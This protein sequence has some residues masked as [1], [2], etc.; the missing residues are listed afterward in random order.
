[1]KNKPTFAA[2]VKQ[3]T[4]YLSGAG[5]SASAVGDGFS[6]KG[7][8]WNETDLPYLPAEFWPQ[9]LLSATP[10]LL[11]V[12]GLAETA[13]RLNLHHVPFAPTEARTVCAL[14]NSS[15]P[16][17]HDFANRLSAETDSKPNSSAAEE[18]EPHP[19]PS[20]TPVVG[21][22][23]TAPRTVWTVKPR[24]GDVPKPL[25]SSAKSATDAQRV[26][27]ASR[28]LSAHVEGLQSDMPHATNAISPNGYASLQQ[29]HANLCTVLLYDLQIQEI[30][31][32]VWLD[33]AKA[34]DD[35]DAAHGRPSTTLVAEL[36]HY[37][38]RTVAKIVRKLKHGPGSPLNHGG[39]FDSVFGLVRK[40]EAAALVVAKHFTPSGTAAPTALNRALDLL[41]FAHG[42]SLNLPYAVNAL[43]S[44]ISAAE[45]SGVAYDAPLTL[46]RIEA[47]IAISS[48]E[49]IPLVTEAGAAT[50]WAVWANDRANAGALRGAAPVS[51]EDVHDLMDELSVLAI[52]QSK[53]QQSRAQA[54]AAGRA[55]GSQEA[56]H[57]DTAARVN[58]VSA[59][60]SGS[61]LCSTA[62][63]GKAIKSH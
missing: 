30:V 55:A 22:P 50:F 23:T 63:C 60:S 41:N 28:A 58:N 37:F 13:D 3:V 8:K 11:H 9:A 45:E 6:F 54:I 57:D 15:R 12:A 10:E 44:A 48:S 47:K 21:Q 59:L 34:A 49:M 14:L 36:T 2:L 35:D 27:S 4:K 62:G 17:E 53:Q 16:D 7:V 39:L 18:S 33:L 46:T 42:G 43:A 61:E 40:G 20:R 19:R 51:V 1:M 32:N 38:D 5:I 25:E 31:F 24:V 56:P 52:S 26:A 29:L